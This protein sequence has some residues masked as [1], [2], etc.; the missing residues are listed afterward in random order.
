MSITLL[1]RLYRQYRMLML[2]SQRMAITAAAANNHDLFVMHKSLADQY[3]H[4]SINIET[5]MKNKK[6]LT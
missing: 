2:E 5:L 1:T 3:D 4:K 6:L